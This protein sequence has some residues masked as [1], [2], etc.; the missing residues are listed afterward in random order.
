MSFDFLSRKD[1]DWRRLC[2]HR[3]VGKI[4]LKAVRAISRLVST[5]SKLDADSIAV[6]GKQTNYTVILSRNIQS[7]PLN[8]LLQ[9]KVFHA[10]TVN[11]NNKT[12]AFIRD[13]VIISLVG[14][15]YY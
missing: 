6:F 9:P 1:L 4:A 10:S 14:F 7:F 12:N 8:V 15:N 13:L 3:N 11:K 5:T 2:F